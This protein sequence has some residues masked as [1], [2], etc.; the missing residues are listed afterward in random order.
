MRTR[1]LVLTLAGALFSLSAPTPAQPASVSKRLAARLA[2]AP[3]NAQPVWVFFRDKGVRP[4]GRLD[5][6]RQILSPR[7]LERRRL[8]GVGPT[9]TAEDLP[10][11]P[12]YLLAVR[13]AG[14]RLRHESR[15]L[16]AVSVE[17]DR[18][19]VHALAGLPFVARL[20]LVRRHRRRPEPVVAAA[21]MAQIQPAKP[22]ALHALDYGES[23]D[24]LAQIQVPALHDQGLHGQG[25]V[26]AV[27]D[28]G[29]DNLSHEAFAAAQIL[30][31]RDFVNQDDDVG[32]GEDRG[33]G[34]HGTATLS[35]LGGFREGRLVGPAFAA[36]F[37]LAKT[38]NTESETPAEEDNWA[39]A[40]EWA[41]ALGADV[42]SSSL[43]YFA[44]DDPLLSYGYDEMDGETAISTRAADLA[45]E[46]GVV[47]VSSAGNEGASPDHGT[48]GAPADGDLVLAAGAVGPEGQRA[49]FSS[50]G[51]TADGRI[52]PDVL[53]QGRLVVAAGSSAPDEYG[54][55]N[56]TSFSCPLLAG[57]AALLLQAHP[58]YTV[59]QVSW[60]LRATASNAATPDNALG[61]GIVNALAAVQVEPPPTAIR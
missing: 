38:E 47:V 31:T 30:L 59:E 54:R 53:A 11:F 18:T 51:P 57:V 13:S 40:A 22:S 21:D 32:D 19:Q 41:E 46:R 2:E 20:E 17:A 48:I 5:E 26:V 34:S 42:I 58:D 56:G 49:I 44:F 27:F 28:S 23:F 45:A 25:I 9:L 4:E 7:A 1:G 8:R 33:E 50:V 61:W 55:V 52:K 43:G 16:N 24:Q 39:A 60:V 6:A 29:F 3:R 14:V 35:V 10:L 15:W 36:G 37:I 12:E